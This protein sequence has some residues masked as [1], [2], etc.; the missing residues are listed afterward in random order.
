MANPDLR[1]DQKNRYH[2]QNSCFQRGG[3]MYLAQV[4]LEL[5]FLSYSVIHDSLPKKAKGLD[6]CVF[7]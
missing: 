1:S 4:Q 5:E 2:L 6:L 7:M 3:G